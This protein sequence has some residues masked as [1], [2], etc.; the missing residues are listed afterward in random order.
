M[1]EI[2]AFPSMAT[3]VC[4]EYIDHLSICIISAILFLDC[5]VLRSHEGQGLRKHLRNEQ[6]GCFHLGNELWVLR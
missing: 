6:I 3:N 5:H 1:F 4:N 2:F